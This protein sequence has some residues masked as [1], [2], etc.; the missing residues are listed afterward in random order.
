[1][2]SLR[3]PRPVVIDLAFCRTVNCNLLYEQFRTQFGTSKVFITVQG[4]MPDGTPTSKSQMVPQTDST[5]YDVVEKEFK[6][7]VIKVD[8][9][10][11]KLLPTDTMTRAEFLMELLDIWET[12]RV[13]LSPH[14]STTIGAELDTVINHT[15]NVYASAELADLSY[16]EEVQSVL[17]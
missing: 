5:L 17:K 4:C 15:R 10:A 12:M 6:Y 8:Y 2:Q 14:L 9:T 1:M 3:E 7:Y 16:L 13:R 11:G